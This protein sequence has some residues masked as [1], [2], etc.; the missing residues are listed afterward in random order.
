M[1]R[2]DLGPDGVAELSHDLRHLLAD[3]FALYN[4]NKEFPL[5]HDRPSLPR[6]PLA[7]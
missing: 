4:E 3:V 7:T 1:A 2:A 5:A 6:L